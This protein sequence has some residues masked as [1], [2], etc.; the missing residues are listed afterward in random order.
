MSQFETDEEELKRLR[1]IQE[2]QGMTNANSKSGAEIMA[3][4]RQEREYQERRDAYRGPEPK[5]HL[6]NEL[7]RSI[8]GAVAHYQQYLLT[9]TPGIFADPSLVT[10]EALAEANKRSWARMEYSI[11]SKEHLVRSLH[12]MVFQE[13]DLYLEERDRV[14]R[15]DIQAVRAK[16]A[17]EHAKDC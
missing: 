4:Y 12:A 8:A 2:Q 5:R 9:N 17:E 1:Y 14:I 11:D 15:A 10:P 6:Q 3:L 13:M 16:M 7:Y